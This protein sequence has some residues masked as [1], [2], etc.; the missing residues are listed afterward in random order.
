MKE[1]GDIWRANKGRRNLDDSLWLETDWPCLKKSNGKSTQ[2]F[3]ISKLLL[4]AHSLWKLI[5]FLSPKLNQRSLIRLG[6]PE[7]WQT[8][9]MWIWNHLSVAERQDYIMEYTCLIWGMSTLN[10][11]VFSWETRLENRIYILFILTLNST[12]CSWKGS[13]YFVVS[14]TCL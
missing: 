6:T 13:T 5:S 3:L 1:V 8:W 4:F 9:Q 14:A 10:L 11:T 7:F 2:F 12:V